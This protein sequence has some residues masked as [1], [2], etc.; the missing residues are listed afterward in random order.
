M[1]PVV[2]VRFVGTVIHGAHRPAIGLRKLLADCTAPGK[3]QVNYAHVWDPRLSD[4]ERHSFWDQR[5]C[6][7]G[8]GSKRAQ[9]LPRWRAAWPTVDDDDLLAWLGSDQDSNPTPDDSKVYS[10]QLVM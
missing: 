3:F 2:D 6:R 9:G 7:I 8:A 4:Q 5:L 10:G 1:Q